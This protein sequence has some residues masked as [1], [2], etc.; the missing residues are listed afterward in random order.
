MVDNWAPRAVRDGG[1]AP[2]VVQARRRHMAGYVVVYW[3]GLF[4][5]FLA[6]DAVSPGS[7]LAAIQSL[8][9]TPTWSAAWLLLG[10]GIVMAFVG[11]VLGS[12]YERLF[13]P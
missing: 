7:I 10:C 12:M 1:D 9:I 13:K 3:V 4:A 5:G 11:A 2:A 8:Y 6:F